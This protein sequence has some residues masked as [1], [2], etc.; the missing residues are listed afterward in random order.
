MKSGG[1]SRT[2]PPARVREAKRPSFS[3]RRPPQVGLLGCPHLRVNKPSEV[4]CSRLA[5]GR[6]E[7][8]RPP[9]EHAPL[10]IPAIYGGCP[11][12][13]N[14]RTPGASGHNKLSKVCSI[15]HLASQRSRGTRRSISDNTGSGSS[16]LYRLQQQTRGPG[17]RSCPQKDAPG[18]ENEFRSTGSR[19]LESG[20]RMSAPINR[21]S[22]CSAVGEQQER[23]DS[24][25]RGLQRPRLALKLINPAAD[26]AVAATL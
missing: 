1:L 7:L 9:T 6:G 8:Q 23:M 17:R 2:I 11:W 10:Q 3:G 21:R 14:L 5:G 22:I 16:R 20:K 15:R 19:I 12:K 4:I 24:I 18:V 13:R 26:A 25:S